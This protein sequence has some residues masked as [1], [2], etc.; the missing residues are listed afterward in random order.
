MQEM[1]AMLE[2]LDELGL[3]RIYINQEPYADV[4]QAMFFKNDL[5]NNYFVHEKDSIIEVTTKYW[6][7]EDNPVNR[8]TTWKFSFN[9]ET[10]HVVTGRKAYAEFNKFFK[11]P[12][13]KDCLKEEDYQKL[14]YNQETERYVESA[15]PVLDFNPKYQGMNID[16]V[17]CYD[18]NSA[19]AYVIS[20]KVI[21]FSSYRT[22]SVVEK[23]EIGFIYDEHLSIRHAGTN[24]NII[25]KMRDPNEDELKY[26]RS[27]FNEKL[28]ST[29]VRRQKAKDMLNLPIGYAQR[30][31]P[32]FRSFVVNICNEYIQSKV[33]KN[34][35]LYNTD[36]IYSL[37]PR[38][39]LILGTY[40]GAF[41]LEE[42]HNFKYIANNYQFGDE[43]PTYRGIPKAWFKS[44][45]V[46][47]GRKWDIL[48]D[49][50]PVRLNKY[51]YLVEKNRIEKEDW[52]NEEED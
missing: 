42:N 11:I 38:N 31:N 32:F 8:P 10:T 25:F 52:W 41:K 14:T 12:T 26:I 19:Y 24:A 43:I 18:L 5:T 28:I 9:D 2:H 46:M 23:G 21:D 29:G 51:K 4:R 35:V 16:T 39:D 30:K 36:S 13:V 34:T 47:T 45:E 48:K 50:V 44:F 7:N 6:R 17:Y 27:W 20:R 40:I 22:N 33:D 1:N 37:K 49:H 15:S 3:R